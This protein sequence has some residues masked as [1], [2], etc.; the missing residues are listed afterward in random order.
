MKSRPSKLD[1][2]AATLMV[3]DGEKKTLADM[4]SWLKAEGCAISLSALG[5]WLSSA[6]QQQLQDRLLGQI[7]SGARQCK[8]VEKQF[9]E[10]PAPELET[11]I[12]LHRV[13]ILQL[14]T[15][16]NADPEFL[17]LADQLMRTAMEFVS[18]QTKFRQK[19]RELNLAE[20]KF[21]FNAAKAALK[22]AATLKL[23]S[24]NK[25]LSEADK[26]NAARAKLF[27][28]LPK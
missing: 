7:A 5:S 12:K 3:M 13:L 1:Q 4:Q 20:E 6:R 27:G 23:I 28:E 14:S 19:E 11:L 15:Q 25:N 8:E 16:G 9:G 2:F 21:E 22:C 17:K 26:V 10:N 24:S 18:G